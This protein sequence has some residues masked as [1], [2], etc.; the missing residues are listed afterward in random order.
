LRNAEIKKF[1]KKVD[2]KTQILV[3]IYDGNIDLW[4]LQKSSKF[5]GRQEK[6]RSA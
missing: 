5:K 3:K 1:V 2:P 6:K 4:G